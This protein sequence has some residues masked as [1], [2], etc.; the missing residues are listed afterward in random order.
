[1]VTKRPFRLPDSGGY[2]FGSFP[3]KPGLLSDKKAFGYDINIPYK[4]PVLF[5]S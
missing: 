1:M 3:K 5:Y 2:Q 4:N